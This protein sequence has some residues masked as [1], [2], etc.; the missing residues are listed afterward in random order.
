MKLSWNFFG[1]N[2][3]FTNAVYFYV[4]TNKN[5]FYYSL[6][7]YFHEVHLEKNHLNL[8]NAAGYFD[9]ILQFYKKGNFVQKAV[10]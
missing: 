2:Y 6:D 9:Y 7:C 8:L 5:C 10:T 3:N 1:K 4:N